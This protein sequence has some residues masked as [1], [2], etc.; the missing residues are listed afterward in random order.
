[1]SACA[2]EAAVDAEA[3]DLCEPKSLIQAFRILHSCDPHYMAIINPTQEQINDLDSIIKALQLQLESGGGE[4]T[5]DEK[6]YELA[7]ALLWHNVTSCIEDGITLMEY[8]LMKRWE[9]HWLAVTGS[10][11]IANGVRVGSVPDDKGG[12]E[13]MRAG[14]EVPEGGPHDYP[15]DWRAWNT[16]STSA[17]DSQR[18][19]LGTTLHGAT[20]PLPPEEEDSSCPTSLVRERGTLPAATRSVSSATTST[21]DT[22]MSAATTSATTTSS[23]YTSAESAH[24]ECATDAETGMPC[25]ISAFG[26]ATA[27]LPHV[28]LAQCYYH[29]AIGYTKLL[30]NDKALFYTDS[31]L[32]LSPNSRDGLLLKRL[33]CARLYVS[34]TIVKSAMALGV[35]ALLL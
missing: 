1:M 27:A 8:V 30:K 5:G 34:R 23:S 25:K 35:I 7:V 6:A 28:R 19:L 2:S 4:E 10:S 16:P 24:L 15:A 20:A 11:G 32:R 14:L 29:L 26:G 9:E 21:G 12:V 3:E 18:V 33:L 31:M 22:K 13:K 17:A